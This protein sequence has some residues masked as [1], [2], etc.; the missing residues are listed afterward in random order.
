[1]QTLPSECFSQ[2][3]TQLLNCVHIHDTAAPPLG[4]SLLSDIPTC[5]MNN[6]PHPYDELL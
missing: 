3:I 4:A 2:N 5:I 1:M 6:D